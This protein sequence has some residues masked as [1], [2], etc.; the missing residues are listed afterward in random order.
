MDTTI[1][2]VQTM[3][4]SNNYVNVGTPKSFPEGINEGK[5]A[6]KPLINLLS[7]GNAEISE[8]RLLEARLALRM[9]GYND[10]YL[11]YTEDNQVKYYPEAYSFTAIH[12]ATFTNLPVYCLLPAEES[13]S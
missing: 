11:V 4:V 12:L 2:T 9:K 6:I 3:L 8:L 10:G 1:K 7:I 5:V 13:V